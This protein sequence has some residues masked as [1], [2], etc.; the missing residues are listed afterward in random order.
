LLDERYEIAGA[1][2]EG[3][4]FHALHDNARNDVPKRLNVEEESVSWLRQEYRVAANSMGDS[5][6]IHHIRI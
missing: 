4:G 2:C 5:K 6:F 3:Q 1:Y